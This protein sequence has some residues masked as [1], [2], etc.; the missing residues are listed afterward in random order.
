MGKETD[1]TFELV[2]DKVKTFFEKYDKCFNGI[3]KLFNDIDDAG[4]RDDK[5]LKAILEELYEYHLTAYPEGSISQTNSPFFESKVNISDDSSLKDIDHYLTIIQDQLQNYLPYDVVWEGQ[6]QCFDSLLVALTNVRNAVNS[7]ELMSDDWDTIYRIAHILCELIADCSISIL[8]IIPLSDWNYGKEDYSCL[9][10]EEQLLAL[11][12][13]AILIDRMY[14]SIH[15]LKDTVKQLNSIVNGFHILNWEMYYYIGFLNFKIHSY[16][17]AIRHF[18]KIIQDKVTEVKD[19]KWFHAMLLLAYCYEYQS[20]Y[21]EAIAQLA[22]PVDCLIKFLL[23]RSYEQITGEDFSVVLKNLIEYIQHNLQGAEEK[24]LYLYLHNPDEA[25]HDKQ[26]EILHALAHCVNEYA[27][28]RRNTEK[29]G[30]AAKDGEYGRLIFFARNL[31]KYIARQKPEYWTCYATIH[32]E[33]SDYKKALEELE[34]AKKTLVQQ[35]KGKETLIAEINFFDYYFKQIIGVN[36]D[37]T[38]KEFESYCRKYTDNDAE[39]HIKAFEFKSELR[40]YYASFSQGII[41]K[42]DFNNIQEKDI[43]QIPTKLTSLYNELCKQRPSLYMNIN[44][45]AE[46]RRMQRAFVCIKLFR[47]YLINR[48]AKRCTM[49]I[50]AL[51]RF[52]AVRYDL[53]LSARDGENNGVLH[54]EQALFV[55]YKK[56]KSLVYYLHNTDSIFLLAPISGVVVFEY[57]TG[58][59]NKLFDL[60]AF[61]AGKNQMETINRDNIQGKVRSNVARYRTPN[62]KNIVWDNLP[63]GIEIYCWRKKEPGKLVIVK[64]EEEPQSRQIIDECRFGDTMAKIAEQN[65]KECNESDSNNFDGK[66]TGMVASL[67]WTEII[68]ESNSLIKILL[69]WRK[70]NEEPKYFIIKA[71]SLENDIDQNICIWHQSVY[72]AS[73]DYSSQGIIPQQSEEQRVNIMKMKGLFRRING[74]ADKVAESEGNSEIREKKSEQLENLISKFEEKMKKNEAFTVSQYAAVEKYLKSLD[75]VK[76]IELENAF[77]DVIAALEGERISEKNM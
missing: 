22:C 46:L 65:T 56:Q 11:L 70:E 57:Q 28:D 2:T 1:G 25:E 36:A 39:C 6:Q 38:R 40:R 35:H 49:L 66:C 73:W 34:K 63:P 29:K 58:K 12:N 47:E 48:D 50:N 60:S 19:D 30:D 52:F 41:R 59:L 21:E 33:C 53:D 42:K 15:T 31:M 24:P 14:L 77:N 61:E 72:N 9:S 67:G 17:D 23:A 3:D 68:N 18:D 54:I 5:K 64:S 45:R 37:D 26:L 74:V 76:M 20:K 16:K 69:Y 51:E 10:A 75:E 71:D 7:A 13:R 27:I 43:P 62:I 8:G 4:G 32:G 55:G 44:V